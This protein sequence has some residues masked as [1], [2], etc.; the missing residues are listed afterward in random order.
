MDVG[1]TTVTMM[2]DT[3]NGVLAN[4]GRYQMAIQGWI[5]EFIDGK[6]KLYLL[7]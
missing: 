7:T 4:T 2:D 6:I 3:S 1:H 5:L